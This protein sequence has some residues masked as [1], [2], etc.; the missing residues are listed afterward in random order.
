MPLH[1]RTTNVALEQQIKLQELCIATVNIQEWS[2]S[3]F[4][5]LVVYYPGYWQIQRAGIVAS[6]TAISGRACLRR[7]VSSLAL[8]THARVRYQAR[9]RAI[10]SGQSS[11]GTSSSPSTSILPCQYHCISV[12]TH[13]S[14][15]SYRCCI[16]VSWHKIFLTPNYNFLEKL[17]VRRVNIKCFERLFCN[18]IQL[19]FRRDN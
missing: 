17:C 8:A 11:I 2:A 14:L 3:R 5:Y 16:I 1:S 7:L 10:Y 12:H 4:G 19:F 9:T 15:S 13:I 6:S 18:C